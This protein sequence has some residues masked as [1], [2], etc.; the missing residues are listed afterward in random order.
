MRP[1]TKYLIAT[2]L[3]IGFAALVMW[4]TFAARDWPEGTA[5]IVGRV[6]TNA[7]VTTATASAPACVFTVT[8]QDRAFRE[9]IG[10]SSRRSAP[11]FRIIHYKQYRLQSRRLPGGELQAEVVTNI[12]DSSKRDGPQIMGVVPEGLWIFQEGPVLCSYNNLAPVLN[13]DTVR[14]KNPDLADTLPAAMDGYKVSGALNALVVKT[15]DLQ[16]YVVDAATGKMSPAD[17][18]TMEADT[19]QKNQSQAFHYLSAYGCSRG[20]TSVNDFR[21][22]SFLTSTGQWYGLLS[23]DKV[24]QLSKW[25]TRN[26]RPYAEEWRQ[27]YNVAY[28]VDDR[29]EPE[30]DPSAVK[31]LGTARF[32]NGGFLM[33]TDRKV[34]DVAGPSSSLQYP[35]P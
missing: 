9:R 33:R 16:F 31:P 15:K 4:S 12:R 2:P 30:I 34:W 18:A 13:L 11:S 29:N 25:P 27:L 17:R 28:T 23:E 1:K 6:W 10:T 7:T 3:F 24:A 19:G 32:L 5:G 22:S 20:S 8:Q 26:D 14:Q 21:I 35:Q